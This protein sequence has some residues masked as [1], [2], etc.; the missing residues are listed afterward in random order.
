MQ[1]KRILCALLASLMLLP[2]AACGNTEEDTG[3]STSTAN[4]A[5]DAETGEETK[6]TLD[7]PEKR[8]DDF[9]LTFITRDEAE[10][11][12]VEIIPDT[13]SDTV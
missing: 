2:L 13:T 3:T 12:T 6:A 11:S 8:F 4:A 9:E 10:W 5:T 1:C 7:L